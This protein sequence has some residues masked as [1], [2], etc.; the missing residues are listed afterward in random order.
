MNRG[1]I[2]LAG[3]GLAALPGCLSNPNERI[4]DARS[5]PGQVMVRA[6]AQFNGL[7]AIED[8]QPYQDFFSALEKSLFLAVQAAP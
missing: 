6:N 7:K 4:F 8:P 2:I 3:L 5:G 1:A